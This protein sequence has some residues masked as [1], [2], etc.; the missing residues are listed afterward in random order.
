MGRVNLYML[1][2][3]F[4][5]VNGLMIMLQVMEFTNTRMEHCIRDSGKMISNMALD[6]KNGLM[7]VAI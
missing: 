1:K 7:A 2:E 3:I 5:M 4:M 6:M